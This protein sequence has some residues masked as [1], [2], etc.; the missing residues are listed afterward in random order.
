M[1]LPPKCFQECA[2]R[3]GCSG[4]Q[5]VKRLLRVGVDVCVKS[6]RFSSPHNLSRTKRKKKMFVQDCICALWPSQTGEEG[7]GHGRDWGELEGRGQ[8]LF[9]LPEL[10]CHLTQLVRH[11][12]GK[13]SYKLQAGAHTV[14][15][16]S[17]LCRYEKTISVGSGPANPTQA[18]WCFRQQATSEAN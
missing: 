6:G 12:Q 11:R 10:H 13:S 14:T 4:L 7:V 2:T 5:C 18:D 16:Q 17:T 15:P 1:A 9:V 3:A 8:S